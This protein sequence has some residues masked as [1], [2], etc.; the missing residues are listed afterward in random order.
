MSDGQYLGKPKRHGSHVATL[1]G[2][3]IELHYGALT[4]GHTV[5][6]LDRS[7]SSPGIA[8]RTAALGG[9]IH[10]EYLLCALNYVKTTYF[11][12][13]G[14]SGLGSVQLPSLRP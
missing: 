7:S 5:R 11:R 12:L 13:F 14:S 1:V 8:S 4:H 2:D 9:Q 3:I 6:K 10:K